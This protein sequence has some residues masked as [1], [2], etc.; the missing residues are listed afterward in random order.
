[1]RIAGGKLSEHRFLFLGAGSAGIGIARHA[2]AGDGV[3]RA[4]TRRG[5]PPGS[6]LFD[7]NGTAGIDAARDLLDFQ[8]PY[9]HRHAPT[10]GLRGSD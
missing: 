8:K 5:A 7:V 10:K 3:G 4:V 2:G 1:M 6:G 9:A